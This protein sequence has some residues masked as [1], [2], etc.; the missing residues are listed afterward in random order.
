MLYNIVIVNIHVH[1]IAIHDM[2]MYEMLYAV[3]LFL[4]YQV[5]ERKPH[6]HGLYLVIMICSYAPLR[7]F[8]E[9]MRPD[10]FNARYFSLTPAQWS[11]IGFLC[12]FAVCL[13]R[14]KRYFFVAGTMP[15]QSAN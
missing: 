8:M 12:L 2:G 5:L 4:T 3:L 15:A 1:V 13:M 14:F 11:I 10:E 7:F 9:F 6:R